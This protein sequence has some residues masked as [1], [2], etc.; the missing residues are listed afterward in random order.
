M[1]KENAYQIIVIGKDGK[2][3]RVEVTSDFKP[4]PN[5]IYQDGWV[6]KNNVRALSAQMLEN[7]WAITASSSLISCDQCF[8]HRLKL[9][10]KHIFKNNKTKKPGFYT[11]IFGKLTPLIKDKLY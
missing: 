11:R 4:D 6:T 2:A 9:I 8:N 3:K 7:E 10:L 1:P 5:F